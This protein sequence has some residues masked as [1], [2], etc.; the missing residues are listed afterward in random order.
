MNLF[1][2]DTGNGIPVL[3]IHGLYGSGDNW[4]HISKKLADSYRVITAD[5]RNHGSSPHD[6]SH[7]YEEMLTDVAW[8]FHE[9][10]IE[11]AHI[12]GHSMGGKI[13]MAF[14]ADYPEKTLSLTVADIAPV[15]Y[16]KKPASALQYDFHKKLLDTL[17]ALNL[18]DFNTRKEVDKELAKTITETHIRQFIIKN[19]DRKKN[20]FSWKINVPVLREYLNH[21]IEGI[22]P[23][24]FDDRIPILQYPVQF[25]RG[26]LSGYI[27]DEETST[28]KRIYPEA[29]IN[30]IEGASHLLHAEKPDEFYQIFRAF[31]D[32]NQGKH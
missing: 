23:D 9:T 27:R 10:G 31:I 7:T 4:M 14:A 3:I 25:I 16:L 8:L 18:D 12:L 2:R 5:M 32:K 30:T 22:G 6:T 20:N 28:I 26:G 19:L 15:N 17:L 1:Y 13:A 29:E 11:K 21:I 24:A